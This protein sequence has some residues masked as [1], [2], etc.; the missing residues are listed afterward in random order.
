MAEET[1]TNPLGGVGITVSEAAERF[2][3]LFSEPQEQ[4]EAPEAVEAEPVDTEEG[5]PEE[6][7]DSGE[8]DAE[9]EVEEPEVTP[10]PRKF[11]VKIDGQEIEVN[12]EELTQGYQR[13]ADYRRKTQEVAEKNR[14]LEAQRQ[15]VE[16]TLNQLIPVLSAQIQDKFGQVDW[17][18]LAREDPSQY[19]ALRAE[20]DA[21][22]Q[23]IQRAVAEQ[24]RFAQANQ[25]QFAENHKKTLESEYKKLTAAIPEFGDPEKGKVIRSEMK[26]YLVGAGYTEQEIN[27]LSDSR[28]AIIAHKAMLYDRAQK[29]R[30]ESKAKP[31]P[32]VQKP[33]TPNKVDP[34]RNAA[35]EAQNRLKKSGNVSDFADYLF[36]SGIT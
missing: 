6:E 1:S 9:S 35:I 13:D 27:M 21:H 22:V 12:E 7:P 25:Q 24:E 3:S 20:Y 5:Q 4:E 8:A 26:T 18:M 2:E 31:L 16:A 14:Q 15:Q 19:V 17:Q 11:K 32:K 33:G 34:K 36:K 28:A 29:A 23:N 10:E 30:Q